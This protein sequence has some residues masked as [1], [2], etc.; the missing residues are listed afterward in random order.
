MF[1]DGEPELAG[2][3]FDRLDNAW[4]Y[5][6]GVDVDWHEVSGAAGMLMMA[7]TSLFPLARK[8]GAGKAS[9]TRTWA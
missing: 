3:S 8:F 9:K 2:T 1:D 7:Y 5:V 6:V 4:R